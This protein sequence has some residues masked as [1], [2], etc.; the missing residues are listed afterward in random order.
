M[1][2]LDTLEVGAWEVEWGNFAPFVTLQNES[3]ISY[4]P[5]LVRRLCLS[6][7]ASL[8]GPRVLIKV[9]IFGLGVS[10]WAGHGDRMRTH[11]E[12]GGHGSA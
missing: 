2:S 6:S 8:A 12:A 9:S 1:S 5:L 3:A 7:E 11:L 4:G 10:F